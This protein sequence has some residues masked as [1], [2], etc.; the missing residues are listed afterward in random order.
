LEEGK[1]VLET[2][3]DNKSPGEDGF[4]AEFYKHFFD[5]VELIS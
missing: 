5:L 4:I 3:K 2:F 1:K